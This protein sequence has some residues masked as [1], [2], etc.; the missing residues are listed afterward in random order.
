MS[1]PPPNFADAYAAALEGHLLRSGEQALHRAYEL[2]RQALAEG[3]G[4]LDIT[5]FHHGAL[6]RFLGEH[7]TDQHETL[8]E[9]AADFLAECLS[10]FEMTLLGYKEANTRLIAA[11]EQLR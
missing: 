10:P 11:H 5:L 3:L 8:L 9:V 1:D 2:G 6:A 7:E 4:L